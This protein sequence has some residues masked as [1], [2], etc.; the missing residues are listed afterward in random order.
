MLWRAA[1]H[2][3]QDNL[4]W[5]HL[6]ALEWSRW[7]A[8]VLQP[9]APILLIWLPIGTV[10]VGIVILNFLWALVRRRFVSVAL[11]DLG[12]LFVRLK[13]IFGPGS[14]AYLFMH[15]DR[16]KAVVALLWPAVT[17]L[18][19]VFPTGQVGNIQTMFMRQLGYEPR[20]DPAEGA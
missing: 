16:T 15:G 6:R 3:D 10:V 19:S 1:E 14:A 2:S 20:Q 18:I 17:L 4:T 8:F 9:V 7:P 5:S 11:A 13:W 12:C